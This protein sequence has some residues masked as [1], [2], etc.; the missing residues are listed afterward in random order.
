MRAKS[1]LREHCN[2]VNL[3]YLLFGGGGRVKKIEVAQYGLKQ[4][5]VLEFLKPYG[6]F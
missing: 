6:F 4:I 2:T 1:S 5:L 3:C